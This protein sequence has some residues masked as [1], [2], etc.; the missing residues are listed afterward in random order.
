M[1]GS[2][3]KA[4]QEQHEGRDQIPYLT[5][6]LGEG[7]SLAACLLLVRS[8]LVNFLS[9]HSIRAAAII[10]LLAGL[11][12]YHDVVYVAGLTMVFLGAIF[13]ARRSIRIQR[14][15]NRIFLGIAIFSLLLAMANVPLVEILGSPLTYQWLDY[16]DFLLSQDAR[17]AIVE[18]LTWKRVVLAAAMTG[19][20]FLFGRVIVF[21][22]EFA[23][24]R[25]NIKALT[26]A[27][28][29]LM[30][31]YLLLAGGRVRRA[32]WDPYRLE[33]PVVVFARSVFVAHTSPSLMTMRTPIEPHDFEPSAGT[34]SS[35]S[36][37]WPKQ[38]S[39]NN[40][41]LIV[42][43]SVPAE[44]LQPYGGSYP[45]T[46]TLER[47][48]S[49]AATFE[50]IYSHA[51]FTSSSLGS[52]LLSIYPSVVQR[53]FPFR[54]HPALVFPSLSSELKQRGYRTAYFSSADDRFSN[55]GTFLSHHGFDVVHDYRSFPCG[56]AIL[57]GSDANWP[58]LDGVDDE[59]T[60]D[61]LLRWI[62]GAPHRPFF[63]M[64]WTMMTHYPYFAE[65]PGIDFGVHDHHFNRYLN[66]LRHDD[67]VIAKLMRFLQE[68]GLDRSTL[69]IVVGDHGE[70]FGR[71]RHF[72]HGTD[73][74]EE[75]VHVPLL[76]IQPNR[77]HGERY[78]Q[79]GGVVDIAPTILDLLGIDPPGLWQGRSLWS[80]SRSGRTY[81]AASFSDYRLGYREGDNKF[82][83]DVAQDRV[84][85]YDLHSDPHETINLAPE[86]PAAVAV[87]KE[88]LA[89][90]AQYQSRMTKKLFTD[91]QEPAVRPAQP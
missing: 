63:A 84:E 50:N 41:L 91:T 55:M 47:F 44:Y 25:F 78:P 9:F 85:I 22:L 77:F 13:L 7:I 59:C 31:L 88:R 70:A 87:A 89:S 60:G 36:S 66:A 5:P 72:G 2:M 58:F 24:H 76:L 56:R 68:Q 67:R 51:P 53:G 83:Y 34:R 4:L 11:A 69:V 79:I 30:L 21:V 6:T 23:R 38:D 80:G 29:A 20:Y 81:F 75:S 45:V 3:E 73:V 61:A 33:N 18:A 54:E 64:F 26:A 43:E 42:L 65:R 1:T 90:W 52:L 82:I 35:A 46:P 71:H 32:S 37:T 14:L 40:I 10:P 27:S 57:V 12:G 19:L 39:A 74:Y 8:Q 62:G 17:N 28:S 86:E 49:E 48:R 16:S 15:L